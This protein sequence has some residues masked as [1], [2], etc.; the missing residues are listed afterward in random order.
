MTPEK[1]SAAPRL[2]QAS[3]ASADQSYQNPTAPTYVVI[4]EPHPAGRDSLG[5]E[6]IVRVRALLKLALRGFGLRCL[7]CPEQRPGGEE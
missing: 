6:A 1:N 5:R 7:S 4:L 2:G 3:G